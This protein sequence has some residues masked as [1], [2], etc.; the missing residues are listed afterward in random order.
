MPNTEEN[1]W[2]N[3]WFTII[4][5]CVLQFFYFFIDEIVCLPQ[6]VSL[7]LRRQFERNLCGEMWNVISVHWSAG[8]ISP[9]YRIK[10]LHLNFWLDTFN[11]SGGIR[12]DFPFFATSSSRQCF[13]TAWMLRKNSYFFFCSIRILRTLFGPLENVSNIVYIIQRINSTP[14][15]RFLFLPFFSSTD[16]AR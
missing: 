15:A 10:Y 7:E 2:V 6:H 1:I 4:W 13:F 12:F 16:F 9:T 11:F 3:S 8:C 5:F 14:S